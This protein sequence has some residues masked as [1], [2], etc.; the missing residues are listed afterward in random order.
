M[1]TAAIA[2]ACIGVVVVAFAR[3]SGFDR[4]KAFYPTTLVVV[5]CYYLLFA[6]MAGVASALFS[7]GLF[8]VMFTA[9][10]VVG[11][12]H[13]PWLVVAGLAAHGAFDLVH[14]HIVSNP[15]VPAW[16]PAFCSAADFALAA[17]VGAIVI[18]NQTS[19]SAPTREA[20]A[21]G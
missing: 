21:R 8:V 17:A 16:W 4:D 20:A 3:A 15:G 12:K 11:F 10:A 1:V 14:V 7:E 13:N 6:A 2:G 5:A 19:A 9:A 18:K